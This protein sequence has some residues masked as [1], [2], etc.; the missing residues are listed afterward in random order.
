M[1]PRPEQQKSP[2][3]PAGQKTSFQKG[4]TST[5]FQDVR[6]PFPFLMV[7]PVGFEPTTSAEVLFVYGYLHALPNFLIPTPVVG[8]PVN[9]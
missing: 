3:I 6:D 1:I 9:L 7:G 8:I 2:I 5:A 4:G